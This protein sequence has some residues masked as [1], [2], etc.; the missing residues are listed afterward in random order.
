MDNR[1]YDLEQIIEEYGNLIFKTCFIMLRNSHDAEDVA[2]ET[3]YKYM[4]SNRAFDSSEHKKAWLLRVSQNKCKDMLRYKKIHSYI[5]YEDVEENFVGHQDVE[6]EDIED[7]LK[8]SNLSYDYKS[9]VVLYYFEGYS[10]EEVADILNINSA[11]VRKRLQRA[12]QKLKI[13]Y[14]NIKEEGEVSYESR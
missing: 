12:R 13:A 3:F 6:S 2:Q 9:V 14:E 1:D 4:I 10:V 5:S 7:I 11:T 8:V